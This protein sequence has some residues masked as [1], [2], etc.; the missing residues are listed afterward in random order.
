MPLVR[1]VSVRPPPPKPVEAAA[2]EEDLGVAEPAAQQEDD[3]DRLL[4]R[5]GG[6]TPK[7]SQ[8]MS[9]LGA[10]NERHSKQPTLSEGVRNDILDNS[11][12]IKSS[13]FLDEFD[14]NGDGVISKEGK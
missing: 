12:K 11:L 13:T 7:R 6:A 14:L 5:G 4:S 3:L 10:N 9:V 1:K 2:K 8:T